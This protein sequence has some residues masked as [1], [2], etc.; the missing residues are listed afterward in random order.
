[1]I[2]IYD[3]KRLFMKDYLSRLEEDEIRNNLMIGLLNIEQLEPDYLVSSAIDDEW[4]VG[5]IAGKNMIIASNTCNQVLYDDMAQHME[6]I[7]YPGIIGAKSYADAYQ[8][9]Y[10]RMHG[11]SMV[12]KMNQRIYACKKLH[13]SNQI[14]GSIRHA[15][16]QDIPILKDWLYDFEM[17]IE[18]HANQEYVL[19]RLQQ[20]IDEKRLYVLEINGELVSMTQ[21]TRPLK[22]SETVSYVYT[23]NQ[24]RRKGYASFLVAFVTKEILGEKP[25]ATLYTDLSNPTSNSIYM[26]IG[27]RPYCDSVMYDIPK[28]LKTKQS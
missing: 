24:Y 28:N 23:P 15:R 21:R 4:L 14:N 22:F 5:M 19:K 10:K 25:M 6:Q 8:D 2:K 20:S 7:N 11:S 3:H 17:Q 12:T 16:S 13:N 9:A 18:G 26:K 1:M 27:Y